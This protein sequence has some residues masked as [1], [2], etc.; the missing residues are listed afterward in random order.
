MKTENFAYFQIRGVPW[1]ENV[2]WY[3][4]TDAIF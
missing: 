2:I 1:I 4:K 3:A